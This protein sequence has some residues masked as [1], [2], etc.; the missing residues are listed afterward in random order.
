MCSNSFAE[1]F[2]E[3]SEDALNDIFAFRSIAYQ[4]EDK[5]GSKGNPNIDESATIYEGVVLLR[6][7]ANENNA[8]EGKFIGV[9]ITAASWDDAR[10]QTEAISGASTVNHGRLQGELGWLHKN[11]SGFSSALR[12]SQGSEYT[13]RTLGVDAH[14]GQVFNEGSTALNLK[15]SSYADTVRLIRFD[16]I[17][18][19]TEKRNTLTFDLSMTQTLTPYSVINLGISHTAQS[20]FLS[21]PYNAVLVDNDFVSETLPDSRKRQA[22]SLR[23][24]YGFPKDSMQLGYSYYEDDWGINAHVAE[25]RYTMHKRNGM[26]RIEPSYR[27]YQQTAADFYAIRFNEP[28]EF[29]TSDSD[30]GDFDGHSLGVLG[31]IKGA[32]FYGRK[33]NYHLG[34]NYYWR[35]DEL[36]F[37][38]FTFGFSQPL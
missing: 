12:F 35:S 5:D 15:L 38:W 22:Y 21:T 14:I 23:Y 16:G 7:R 37:Y 1:T 31:S 24:K 27:Y 18:E 32:G 2:L 10:A 6:K 19:P 30:L 17:E 3:P 26:L 33:A 8:F 25:M 4:Q 28:S 11:D 34:A 29:L 13:Y 9:N 36:N 20:G